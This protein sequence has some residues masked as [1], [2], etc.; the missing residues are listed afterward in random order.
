LYRNEVIPR[1]EQALESARATWIGGRGLFTDVL[2]TRR[3][4][5]EGQLMHAASVTEQYKLLSELV[6]CCGLGDLEALKMIAAE[7]E[8]DAGENE[9]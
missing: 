4:L 5:L 3:I 1:A 8:P 7:M 9:E 2:D 6:L